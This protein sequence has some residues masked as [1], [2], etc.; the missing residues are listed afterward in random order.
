MRG[1]LEEPCVLYGELGGKGYKIVVPTGSAV[2]VTVDDP[3][4]RSKFIQNYTI[5]V[6]MEKEKEEQNGI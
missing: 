2:E 3:Q 4:E 6:R 5:A 1:I